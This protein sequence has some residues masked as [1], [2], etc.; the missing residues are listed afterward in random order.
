MNI[1][2]GRCRH[3]FV[4]HDPENPWGCRK[5]GFKSSTLPSHA[6]KQTT[7]T[8]CAYFDQLKFIRKPER[9]SNAK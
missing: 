5:F 1:A 9:N 6:V 2:C 4:S 7:G 3:Y 8:D